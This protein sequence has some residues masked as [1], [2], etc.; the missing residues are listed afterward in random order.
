MTA[1]SPSAFALSTALHGA[2]AGLLLAGLWFAQK[3]LPAKPVIFELVAGPGDN[4]TATEA[5][6]STDPGAVKFNPPKPRPSPPT[7]P[8]IAPPETVSPQTN[9][10]AVNKPTPTSTT[11]AKKLPPQ[12]PVSA[13]VK[14]SQ[15][16]ADSIINSS[17]T[18]PSA[19]RRGANGTAA[20]RPDSGELAAY[21]SLLVQNLHEAEKQ[22][23]PDGLPDSLQVLVEFHLN[24]D[25]SVAGTPRILKSSGNAAFDKSVL[26]AFR[27]MRPLPASPTGQAITNTVL[28][29]VHDDN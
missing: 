13:Q 1:R 25:G 22:L 10:K 28:F 16:N 9:P 7:Q 21:F 3:N 15:I 24:A 11:P 17:Y 5:P 27:A 20:T 8:A 2:V 6:T 18:T 26:A 29:N 23:R 19:N 4:F 14:V 12:A